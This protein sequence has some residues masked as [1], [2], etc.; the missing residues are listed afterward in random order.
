MTKEK[1]PT[2]TYYDA[3]DKVNSWR[4]SLCKAQREITEARKR[5]SEAQKEIKELE[6]SIPHLRAKLEKSREEETEA[7]KEMRKCL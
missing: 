7:W 1:N 5:I 2:E 6:Y 4:E 3:C